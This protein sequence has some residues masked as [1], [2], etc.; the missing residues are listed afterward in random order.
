MNAEGLE[1]YT[2][3][4]DWLHGLLRFGQKPGLERMQWM[5]G[6]L[7]NPERRLAFIH[8]AADERERLYL[9]LSEPYADGG[10]IQCRDVHFPYLIDFR[11]RIRYNGAM[12]PQADL[13]ELVEQA[14]VLV[15]RCEAESGFGSPTEF[16]VI[17]LIAILYFANVTRLSS[18]GL[19]NGLGRTTGLDQCR[20][21]DRNRHYEHRHGS[22]GRTRKQPSRDCPGKGGDHQ[23][24]GTRHHW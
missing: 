10:R 14:R 2:K 1:G 24:G 7:G 22:H 16:E 6:Q 20:F 4:L 19:G 15:E 3:A 23:A 8:V 13:V 12:I 17:T 5:L 21:P 9:L 11:E 18:R